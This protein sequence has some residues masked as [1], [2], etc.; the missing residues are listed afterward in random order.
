MLDTYIDL[1]NTLDM[2]DSMTSPPKAASALG[3]GALFRLR[4][5]ESWR[6][7]WTMYRDLRGREPVHHVAGGDYWV[8]SRFDDVFDAARDTATFS[9]AQGLT[10][11]YGEME[12]LGMDF[13]PMV[14]LDPPEHTAFRRMVARGFVPRR[15]ETIEPM[16]RAFVAERMD[17]LRAEGSGDLVEAL[18][19]PLPSFVVALYLGVP[20]ADRE[21]FDHWT[22]EIVGANSSGDPLG[23]VEAVAELAAYFSEL[24]ER[25]RTEPGD[26]VVSDLVS[27]MD[28]PDN[29]SEVVDVLSILGFAFT[30]VAGGNDTTTGLLGGA[31]ELLTEHRDQ[32]RLIL[33]GEVHMSDAVEELLRLTSP[34]QGLAR[35]TTRDVTVRGRTIPAG[36][37]VLLLYAS[38]NRDE[39]QFGADAEELDLR[40][41]ID[42]MLTFGYG[43][44]HCLGAAAARLQARV[45]IEELLR[46]CPGFEVD[47]A[48]GEFAAGNYVRRYSRLPFEAG[49]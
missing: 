36:R 31:A 13:A 32:R 40:R 14:M 39:S 21:R 46:H 37:K 25:R 45:A 49:S 9:S 2:P 24:I 47:A 15:V 41:T 33:E 3:D 16:V 12:A 26:D 29:D 20:E 19:K 17:A 35:T 27:M 8:L 48:G 22:E 34:V 5:G 6:D 11:T 4:S 1:S 28:D 23:A 7:P 30:M 43:A 44:H 42:R 38:A 10:V 18:A